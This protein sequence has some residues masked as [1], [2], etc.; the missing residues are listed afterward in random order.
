MDTSIHESLPVATPIP[1]L[2]PLLERL[3]I[4]L[5]CHLSNATTPMLWADKRWVD[6]IKELR[7]IEELP[8]REANDLSP[9]EAAEF[10]RWVI[11][12]KTSV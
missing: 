7:K 6:D 5:Y 2:M 8:I 12:K 4:L 10:Y 11:Q 1:A 9:S 3:E